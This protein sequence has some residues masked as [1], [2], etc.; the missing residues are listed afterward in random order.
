MSAWKGWLRRLGPGFIT[1]AADD[2]PSGIGTYSQT[3]AMF[4]YGHLWLAPYAYPLMVAVQESCARICM[5]TGR[6]LAAILKAYYP[7]WVLYVSV[8]LLLVANTINIAADLGAMAASLLILVNLPFAVWIVVFGVF[9][10]LMEVFI[11]YRHYSAILRFLS[12][13][14]LA[15]V[16]TALIV[17]QDWPLVLTSLAVPRLVLDE[18][19]MM[20]VVAFL[21]TTISPYLFFWQSSQQVE[22]EIVEQR[23]DIIGQTPPRQL[24][25]SDLKRMRLD[26]AIG[27]AFSQVSAVA[28]VLT[29]AATLHAHGITDIQTAPQAA[30]ALRPLAGDLAYL[31]FALGIIGTGLLG[32]PVLAGSSAYAVSEAAGWKGGLGEKPKSAP[33]FYAVIAGSTLAGLVINFTGINPITALYFAA[34]VNGVTAPPLMVIILLISRNRTIMGHHRSGPLSTIVSLLGILLMGGSALYLLFNL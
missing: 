32:V 9:V 33:L 13:S 29:T 25:A 8:T 28:I 30:E 31:L 15:Y 7:R 34:V 26:T 17:Q 23:P 4:G 20:N 18:A 27:M 14:L 1:G 12:L 2:D 5:V 22:E 19:S 6:G 3:G 24:P 21:G 11:D 10:V 16:A